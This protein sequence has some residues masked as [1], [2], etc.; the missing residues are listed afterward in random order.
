[1][2]LL[3]YEG[4]EIMAVRKRLE[5]LF[6]EEGVRFSVSRHD[7]VYSAQRVAGMLH[8]PGRQLAKVVMVKA[9]DKLTMLVV[10][11]PDRVDLNKV[12]KALKA[13]RVQLAGEKDFGPCFPDCEVGAMPPF[14]NLYEMVVYV[15]RALST[16]N[17]I[18]FPAGTHREIMRVAYSDFERIVE[19]VLADLCRG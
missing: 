3:L 11:A 14:G 13:D 19:P 8:I 5:R 16:Q 15:D 6:R 4:G 9:D 2:T 12:K 1:V 18:A 17:Q 7:E 10:P